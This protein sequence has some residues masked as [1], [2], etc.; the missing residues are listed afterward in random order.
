MKI[1]FIKPFTGLDSFSWLWI[2]FISAL[3]QIF[4]LLFFSVAFNPLSETLFAFSL[5]QKKLLLS[6]FFKGEDNF[7]NMVKNRLLGSWAG[8]VY[9]AVKR[10]E[11]GCLLRSYSIPPAIHSLPASTEFPSAKGW[12]CEGTHST[13]HF[14]SK[15][16]V[17]WESSEVPKQQ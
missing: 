5:M 3:C 13:K 17:D 2:V 14:S 16:Q 9:M 12:H 1:Q 10:N 4:I 6:G 8:L 15:V 11:V 7:S